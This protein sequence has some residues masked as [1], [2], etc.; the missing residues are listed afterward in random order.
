[1]SDGKEAEFTDVKNRKRNTKR[2]RQ[3]FNI[4]KILKDFYK[5]SDWA[6]KQIYESGEPMK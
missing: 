2:G 5:L 6:S 4:L 3:K 1:M